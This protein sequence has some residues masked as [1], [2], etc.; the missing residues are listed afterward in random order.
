MSEATRSTSHLDLEDR[1]LLVTGAARGLGAC[2]AERAAARGARLLLGD[3]RDAQGEA[4]AK[5]IGGAT[6]YLH[7][8]VA[9]EEDWARWVEAA[10]A[11]WGRIDALINDAAILHIG[12]LEHTPPEVFEQVFRVNT[13]GPFLGIRAV[14]PA[15]KP[16]GGRRGHLRVLLGMESA[17]RP[18]ARKRAELNPEAWFPNLK[19]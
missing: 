5:Q 13:L 9:R 4:V 8:D 17:R 11:E 14:L 2:I 6:R 19:I 18:R 3:V 16:Q 1:V 7:L 12:I 10:L 15:M